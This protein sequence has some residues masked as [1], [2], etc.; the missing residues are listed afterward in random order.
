MDAYPV[1]L[2]LD[3]RLKQF[4][5]LESLG[6]MKDEASV[7]ERFVQQIKFNG[8]RYEVKQTP[9]VLSE[10]NSIIQDRLNKGIVEKIPQP[11]VVV[12]DH[13]HYYLPHHGVVRQDKTTSKL[14]IVYNASAISMTISE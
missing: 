7:Y 5:E 4:W 1:E 9:Q 8:Q 6:L 10:Y 2:S 11:A 3:N 13:A 14:R 12:S